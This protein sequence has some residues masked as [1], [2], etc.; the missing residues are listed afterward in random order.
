MSPRAKY[1]YTRGRKA[2][3]RNEP[4]L[5]FGDSPDS[6]NLTDVNTAREAYENGMDSATVNDQSEHTA[7]L[8]EI[9]E[10]EGLVASRET[11]DPA[12]AAFLLSRYR[13]ELGE[14]EN[15]L[16]PSAR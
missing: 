1:W 15:R 12:H 13:L 14:L 7:R 2:V 11:N 4:V 5:D 8:I 9:R 16:P 10:F 3:L 6:W